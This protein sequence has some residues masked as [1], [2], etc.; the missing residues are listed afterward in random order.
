MFDIMKN[1]RLYK[2][3]RKMAG[4]DVSI[5]PASVLEDCLD[6]IASAI[7]NASELPS[8][9]N[10]DDGKILGVVNGGWDKT[11]AP[12]DV[13]ILELPSTMMNN[14]YAD[15][16]SFAVQAAT[17]NA[18][19]VFDSGH[20]LTTDIEDMDT[21]L[22]VLSSIYSKHKMAFV[23]LLNSY[24]AVVHYNDSFITAHI[25]HEQSSVFIF[26][27]ISI[28]PRLNLDNDISGY[29]CRIAGFA[30]ASS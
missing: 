25:L 11:D 2:F 9:T 19:T 12:T 26:A 15:I 10:V 21:L 13:Y 24:A 14:I 28:L 18:F 6:D 30:K 8:V 5:T 17:S 27:D 3:L 20:S 23:S 16:S 29:V 4:D 7:G 22:S 1:S